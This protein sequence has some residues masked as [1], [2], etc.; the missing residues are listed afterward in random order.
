MKLLVVGLIPYDAGKTEFVIGMSDALK[1]LGY[2]PGYFKPVAGHDGWYQYDTLLY[3]M[4]LGLLIGH[5]AYVVAERLELLDKIH[6]V[7]PLDIL[8]FPIDLY[9]ID[10]NVHLYEE[11]MSY[12]GKRAVLT[13]FTRIYGDS[14]DSY[15]HVYFLAK[16]AIDK[17]SDELHSVFGELVD[18]LKK[19][20]SVFIE[21]STEY[22][23]KMLNTPVIYSVIDTYME[24]LREYD[25]LI[26]E[27]YNDVASPTMKSLE[28]DYVFVVGPGKVLVYKGDRYRMAVE[29]LSYRGYPWTIKASTVISVAGKPIFSYDI[30]LKIYSEKY[31]SL[32]HNIIEVINSN[33]GE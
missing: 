29:L 1:E 18:N 2:K 15:K 24:Y 12:I 28:A 7:S 4:D 30:P 13:R 16:D 17:L 11:Y 31:K 6:A 14:I 33:L 27:G 23:E 25:P 22:V 21:T 9:K 5:D 8:T 19:E 3:S 20:N 26:I 10:L 32:F